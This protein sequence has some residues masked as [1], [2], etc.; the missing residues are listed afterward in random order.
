MFGGVARVRRLTRR[1]LTT[2][3][4]MTRRTRIRIAQFSRPSQRIASSYP[5][6]VKQPSSVKPDSSGHTWHH[7][8]ENEARRRHPRVPAAVRRVGETG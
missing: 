1:C 6:P 4:A 5:S 2:K 8:P 3:T 7:V